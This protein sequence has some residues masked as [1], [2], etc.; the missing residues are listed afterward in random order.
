L[1]ESLANR[2][3]VRDG[4]ALRPA[5]HHSSIAQRLLPWLPI[6]CWLLLLA[7]AAA[8]APRVRSAPPWASWP[9]AHAA[10]KATRIFWLAHVLVRSPASYPELR[11]PCFW[12]AAGTYP[13][14]ACPCH[15]C[16]GPP[17]TPT[18]IPYPWLSPWLSVCIW[19]P[20]LLMFSPPGSLFFPQMLPGCLCPS[21][22]RTSQVPTPSCSS[23]T[24]HPCAAST[25]SGLYFSSE[26]PLPPSSPVQ[27][28]PAP[29]TS[30]AVRRAYYR[31]GPKSW[32]QS[33][34][35]QHRH[36]VGQALLA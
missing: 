17:P 15:T 5:L 35:T 29:S 12:V 1:P 10:N 13:V 19:P 16:S 20:R 4:A 32:F 9:I 14:L 8:R 30:S 25:A 31:T 34:T 26:A 6:C 27:H 36:L 18:P 33:G 23:L 21:A 2:L 7:A 24:K 11:T 28:S 3:H 22:G